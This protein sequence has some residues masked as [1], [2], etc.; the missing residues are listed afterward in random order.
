MDVNQETGTV[1]V[2]WYDTRN[3]PLNNQRVEVYMN[4]ST[5]G[6]ESFRDTD[7]LLSDYPSDESQLFNPDYGTGTWHRDFLEYIG[8]A[9]YVDDFSGEEAIRAVWAGNPDYVRGLSPYD[10]DIYTD[11]VTSI[12]D[13]GP[14]PL[15][16]YYT[17]S[18]PKRVH[19][20]FSSTIRNNDTQAISTERYFALPPS[21][22][23][24]VN[25]DILALDYLDDEMDAYTD[26]W[27]RPSR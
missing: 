26:E 8:V 18:N 17:L 16:R 12:V 19:Y 9:A 7:I 21:S 27:G 2:V 10:L 6:G 22:P 24:L 15:G 3:D 25:Q 20:T 13:T 5:N 23:E 11:V 14:S 4:Y 1:A